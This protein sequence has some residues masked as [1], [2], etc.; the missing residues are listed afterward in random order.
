MKISS[1]PRWFPTQSS[2]T[3]TCWRRNPNLFRFLPT[4][5]PHPHDSIRPRSLT[6][7]SL[8]MVQHWE[9]EVMLC[10]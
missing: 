2:H 9:I 6:F 3:F 8:L 5:G 7:F 4:L 10:R 1:S